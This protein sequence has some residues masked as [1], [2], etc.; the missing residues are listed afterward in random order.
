MAT[1]TIKPDIQHKIDFFSE[2]VRK[3]LGKNV[4]KIILYGSRARGD[5]NDGSDYD[6]IIIVNKKNPEV[7]NLASAAGY[8]FLNMYDE[9]AAEI[10]FDEKE[11]NKQRKFPLGINAEREGICI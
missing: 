6:F 3:R 2:A 5:Y 4:K 11:W 9:L 1:S 7:E 10:I 8:D